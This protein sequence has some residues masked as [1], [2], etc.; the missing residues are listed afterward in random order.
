MRRMQWTGASAV[1]AVVA[2]G[3]MAPPVV[4]QTPAPQNLMPMSGAWKLN[5]EASTNPNG[6][7]EHRAERAPR[8]GGGV[9]GS[10]AGDIAGG[11]VMS[12]EGGGL[13]P[14][15]MAR[16]NAAKKFYFQAPPIMGIQ[17][18]KDEIRMIYDPTNGPRF[19]HKTDNKQADIATPAGPAR[20]K[21][22]WDKEKLRREIETPETL[23]VVEEYVLSPDGKQLTVTVKADSRMVRNVQDG[24][25]KR[26]YDRTQ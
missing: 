26:V 15:E 14:E 13:G 18:T 11:R 4:A 12:A 1:A 7:P 19:L 22:K 10:D 24:D 20:M 17:A 8:G 2:V 6:P 21:V 3:L 23:H 9:G 16:L 5:V 25:I